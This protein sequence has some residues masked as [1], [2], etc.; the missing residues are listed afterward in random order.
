MLKI[1]NKIHLAVIFA[2]SATGNVN[3][4]EWVTS[5][6]NGT[7]TFDDWGYVG[8]NGRT[9]QDFGSINGFGGLAEGNTLDSNGG[10]GQIQHVITTGPDGLTPDAMSADNFGYYPELFTDSVMD[11]QVNFYDQAYTTVAGSTFNNMQIDYDGDYHIARE[12][13]SFEYY[14]TFD[15]VK[16]PDGSKLR[17]ADDGTYDTAIQFKPYALSD[18]TGWCGSV[19]ASNPGALEAMAGQVQ[20]DFVFE[21]FVGRKGLEGEGTPGEGSLQIVPDFQMRSYGSLTIDMEQPDGTTYTYTADAVVNNTNPT[22][23]SVNPDTGLNEVGGAGVDEDYY[24]KVSF[25]GGGS[26]SPTVFVRLFDTSTYDAA[27]QTVFYQQNIDQVFADDGS[28]IAIYDANGNFVEAQDAVTG[29]VLQNVVRHKNAFSGYGF[30]LRAD[31]DR[32]IDGFD[33][34]TYSDFSGVPASAYDAAGNLINLEGNIIQDLSASAVPVPAAVWLF[35]SGLLA[36]VGVSRRK[37]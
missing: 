18:A 32:I 35:G 28:I 24:N 7:A 22:T 29:E 33:F 15:Y 20:F 30:I 1:N 13:M 21:S 36:L 4:T 19:L 12:D 5:I 31:G 26:V 8:P 2:L 17:F 9:A 37:K 25:M 11:S 23:G 34:S 27:T 14:K 10:I 3:A 16:D 6:T